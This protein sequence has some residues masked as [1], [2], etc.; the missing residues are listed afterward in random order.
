VSKDQLIVTIVIMAA[1]VGGIVT[2]KA[3]ER[4]LNCAVDAAIVGVR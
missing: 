1:F 2:G 3:I 4:E